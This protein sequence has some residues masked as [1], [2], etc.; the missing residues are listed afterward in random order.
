MKKLRKSNPKKKASRY[1]LSQGTSKK[2]F[3]IVIPNMVQTT[4]TEILTPGDNSSMR[5]K[6]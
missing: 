6:Y 3:K 2:F 5:T 1:G 4:S